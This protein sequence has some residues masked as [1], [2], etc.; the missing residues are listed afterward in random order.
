M[1]AKVFIDALK[2]VIQI[3]SYT[4]I[5]PIIIRENKEASRCEQALIDTGYFVRAVHHST[6]PKGQSRLRITITAQHSVDQIS[7]LAQK[8]NN[9]MMQNKAIR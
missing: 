2:A 5:Q 4:Q 7:E 8:I 9:V 6:V 1:Y 3:S